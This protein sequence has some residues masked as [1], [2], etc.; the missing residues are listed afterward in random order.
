MIILE[1]KR[2]AKSGDLQTCEDQYIVSEDYACVIDG[3]TDVTGLRFNGMTS[4]QLISLGIAEAIPQLPPDADLPQIIAIIN[5]SLRRFYK[6]QGADQ[7]MGESPNTRPAAAMALYSRSRHV[8]WLVGDCQCMIDDTWHTNPKW[9]D[10]ITAN[11]RALYIEA[12]LMSGKT[13]EELMAHDT[14]WEAVKPFIQMQYFMQNTSESTPYSYASINGFDEIRHGYKRIPVP[15]EARYLVLA[16]DGYPRLEP[17]LEQSEQYLE[18][19]LEH[20]PLC[21]REHKLA[22]G[23]L[24]GNVS[25]DDRTYLKIELS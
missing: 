23:M 2:A 14:G 10:D 1:E 4:G 11:A 16:S 17:T 25:F 24:Q 13:V 20:D 9:I 12:E 6:E 7:V 3:A 22:K 18:Y 15:A 19:I 5:E 21:I 8:V